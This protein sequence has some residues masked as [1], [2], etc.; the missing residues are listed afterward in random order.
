MKHIIIAIFSI[1][2]I[3]AC[4]EPT[5]T[6]IITDRGLLNYNSGYCILGMLTNNDRDNIYDENNKPITCDGYIK[7]TKKEKENYKN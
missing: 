6:F 1:L 3:A 2:L 5:S 4:N 7:L